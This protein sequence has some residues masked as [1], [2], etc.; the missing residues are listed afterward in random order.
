MH[1]CIKSSGFSS[2]LE[3]HP[4]I[5]PLSDG[6]VQTCQ[7]GKMMP[8]L[9]HLRMLYHT[10]SQGDATISHLLSAFNGEQWA[11]FVRMV[12][13]GVQTEWRHK[14]L[15]MHLHNSGPLSW[16]YLTCKHV[17]NHKILFKSYWKGFGWWWS[18]FERGATVPPNIGGVFLPRQ[19]NSTR[20]ITTSTSG[21][22]FH[23]MTDEMNFVLLRLKVSFVFI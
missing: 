5:F 14:G 12:G 20:T 6:S 19:G 4:K 21:R 17:K 7:R 3:I 22:V 15:L 23:G 1:D 18:L 9:C 2:T 10:F 11:I 13:A 16:S 8:L